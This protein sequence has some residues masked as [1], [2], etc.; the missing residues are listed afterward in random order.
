MPETPRQTFRIEEYTWRKFKEKCKREGY[1]A[2]EVLRAFIRAVV[3]GK[4]K[5][6]DLQIEKSKP[7]QQL[8]TTYY[9]AFKK[10]LEEPFS[11]SPT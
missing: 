8:S 7:G 3:L 2:S 10:W 6:K 4:I 5:L 1:R 11:S 9:E